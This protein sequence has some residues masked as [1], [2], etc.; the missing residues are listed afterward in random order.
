MPHA[1][2]RMLDEGMIEKRT[3]SPLPLL[4]S[5]LQAQPAE[6]TGLAGPAG[7][8]TQDRNPKPKLIL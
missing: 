8:Q 2:C 6:H 7:L 1:A 5:F 3:N 4:L